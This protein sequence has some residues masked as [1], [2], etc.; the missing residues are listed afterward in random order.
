MK[1]FEQKLKK[2]KKKEHDPLHAAVLPPLLRPS[3][4][5]KIPLGSERAARLTPSKT[6]VDFSQKTNVNRSITTTN[7]TASVHHFSPRI[8]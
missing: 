4:S 5:I 7:T 3:S 6:A 2:N 8:D 1:V